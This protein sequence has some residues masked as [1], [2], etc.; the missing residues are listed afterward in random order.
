M[1]KFEKDIVVTN[2]GGIYATAIELGSHILTGDEPV[3]AGGQ[4]A[5]PGAHQFLLA[6]L[7]SCMA[8]TLRMY[9]QRKE[10]NVTKISVHLNIE[11]DKEAVEE[12]NI[13]YKKVLIEGD[14]T[15]EQ[16]NRLMSIA[17][18]CPVHKL[19]SGKIEF[20]S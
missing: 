19:L 6:S 4:D 16:R 2:N 5:G 18:K 9:V 17:E 10:W 11:R 14:I 20:R 8:I 3:K 7:G 15:E 12:T 13:I 1:K